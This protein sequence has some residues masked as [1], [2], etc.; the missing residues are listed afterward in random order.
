MVASLI[1]GSH[2]MHDSWN[3]A[4]ISPVAGNALWSESVASEVIVFL[5]VGPFLLRHVRPES[6]MG[7]SA[8]ACLVRWGLLAQSSRSI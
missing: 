2:A 3:A 6:A 8:V 7:V 4:G 1:L 5:V